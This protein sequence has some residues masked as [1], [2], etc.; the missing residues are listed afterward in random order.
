MAM[1][2]QWRLHILHVKRNKLNQNGHLEI[3]PCN[4]MP[5]YTTTTFQNFIVLKKQG[6]IHFIYVSLFFI[7]YEYKWTKAI[8]ISAGLKVVAIFDDDYNCTYAQGIF[9]R[10]ASAIKCFEMN[11]KPTSNFA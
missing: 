6:K 5:K 8:F 9:P 11:F 4:C 3:E 2:K 10:S 7:F 1:R